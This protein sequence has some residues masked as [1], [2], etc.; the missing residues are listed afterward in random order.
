[1]VDPDATSGDIESQDGLHTIHGNYTCG[2]AT[3]KA[4][5][6]VVHILS[7]SSA[8]LAPFIPPEPQPQAHAITHRYTLLLFQQPS[9]FEFPLAFQYALPLNL[10]NVTNRLNFNIQAFANS[11]GTTSRLVAAN[12][13]DIIGPIKSNST[14]TSTTTTGGSS[15]T[16][17]GLATS[18]PSAQTQP[19]TTNVAGTARLNYG[20]ATA[21]AG[22]LLY[23]VV[24]V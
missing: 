14:S 8:A 7:S 13:F 22:F 21:A 16:G 1:M 20:L 9:G 11:L 4:N 19:S 12:T 15:S 23:M 10:S 5:D 24:L 6:T 17:T 2:S 18:T 3:L